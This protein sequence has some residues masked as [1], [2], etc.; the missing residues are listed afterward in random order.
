MQTL[1]I[2]VKKQFT[3]V[4]I[5]RLKKLCYDIVN[6]YVPMR[7]IKKAKKFLLGGISNDT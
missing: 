4:E 5:K 2:A 1:Q 7:E 3:K 6:N